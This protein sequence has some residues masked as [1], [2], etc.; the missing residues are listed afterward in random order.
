MNKLLLGL[1]VIGL[2]LTSCTKE[3]VI[4]VPVE[5]IVKET[6]ILTETITETVTV[7]LEIEEQ[8]TPIE[9]GYVFDLTEYEDIANILLFKETAGSKVYSTRNYSDLGE[10]G[11]LIEQGYIILENN[12]CCIE[13]ARAYLIIATW[14]GTRVTHNFIIRK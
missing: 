11:A 10:L 6:I 9:S 3:V 4:E 8:P 2:G 14:D 1:A 5:T 7:T 13:E 12:S